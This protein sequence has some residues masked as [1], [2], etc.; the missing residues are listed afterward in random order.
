MKTPKTSKH[1]GGFT[2]IELMVAMAITTVI[3]TVLVSITGI[4]LD[5]WQRGR[6]EIRASRQAKSM[7]DTMA[8][9]FESLV[10]RRGNNFEWLYAK[11]ADN[12]PGP[13]ANQSSNA[14][15]LIF[16]TAATDRYLGQIGTASDLGGDVSC[17]AYKLEYQDPVTGEEEA[18]GDSSTFVFY[19]YLVDPKETFDDLLGQADLDDAFSSK[20]DK[21]KEPENFVCE[22]IY[23]FTLT[24]QVEVTQQQTGGTTTTVPVRVTLGENG[25]GK[26]MRLRGNGI[27]TDASGSALKPSVTEDEL[28]AGRLT[29]VEIGVTV[30]SDSAVIRLNNQQLPDAARE[31]ILAAESFQYSRTV[32]LPGM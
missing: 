10:S 28:K 32:E 4:A 14:A 8:K 2:L 1:S 26:E 29:G 13:S 24:F 12:L 7:L 30:L 5:S 22:N 19:R 6:S 9:D 31:K 11:V 17:V 18:E 15:D 25:A 3:V 27:V 21:I 23:Q 16:F 20:D